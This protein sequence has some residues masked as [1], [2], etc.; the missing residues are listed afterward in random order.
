MGTDPWTSVLSTLAPGELERLYHHL[1]LLHREFSPDVSQENSTDLPSPP[2]SSTMSEH[3]R[4]ESSDSRQQSQ[5]PSTIRNPG[6]TSTRTEDDGQNDPMDIVYRAIIEHPEFVNKLADV[7]RSNPGGLRGPRGPSGPS[8]P[9]GSPAG[10]EVVHHWRADEVGFFFPDLHHSYGSAEIVT[11]GK[12]SFYRNASVFLD[13]LDDMVRLKGAELVWI[14][15]PTCLRGAALQWYM[16]ELT[17]LEKASFRSSSTS[18]PQDGIYRWCQALKRRWDP[19]ASVALQNFMSTKFTVSMA[20]AGISV[21]QYFSTKLRLAKEAGF[22]NVHQ[23]LLAVWNGID[24]EIR[25]QIDE[26]DEHTSIDR[27]RRKLE[28]KERLWKE[29]LIMQRLRGQGNFANRR[30]TDAPPSTQQRAGNS[31]PTQSNNRP[32][33]PGGQ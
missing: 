10:G 20:R 28:D 7:L 19:P 21:V 1:H 16:T 15:L 25:E 23:Q 6:G 8:G 30:W 2:V 18:N 11:I 4:S 26:P 14:N 22:D 3:H 29:K 12:D 5:S 24:I 32:F 17:D 31:F 9:L 33:V 27:F 13:R